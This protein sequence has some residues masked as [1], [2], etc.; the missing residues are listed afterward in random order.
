MGPNTKVYWQ[1][2]HNMVEEKSCSA[3]SSQE[4]ERNLGK[5]QVQDGPFKGTS[6]VPY[7]LHTCY[8][9]S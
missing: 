2:R 8:T 9:S 3:H 4:A 1:D 7:F 6:N 5:D